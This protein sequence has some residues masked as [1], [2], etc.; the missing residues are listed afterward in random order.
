MSNVIEFKAKE[1]PHVH[2][3]AFCLQCKYEWVGVAP[4]GT[5]Q[6]ECPK[7]ETLKGLWKFPVNVEVG[8]FLINCQCGNDLFRIS[9]EGYLCPNCG[10][11]QG[12]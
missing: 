12:F 4:V 3:E 6:L 8:E 10:I 11:L 9:P 2:G 7:C 5:K 1:E